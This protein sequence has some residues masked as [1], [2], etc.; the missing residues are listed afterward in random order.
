MKRLFA[1]LDTQKLLVQP[2]KA[3]RRYL[4]GFS[5]S[6][7]AAVGMHIGDAEFLRSAGA[8]VTH[9]V[10]QNLVL[11]SYLSGVNRVLVMHIPTAAWR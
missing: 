7:P 4:H 2:K 5:N 11:A 3:C 1:G 6:S 10:L 8:R 9:D